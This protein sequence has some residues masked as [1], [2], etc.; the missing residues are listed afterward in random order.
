M[1]VA[2]LAALALVAAA[3]GGAEPVET[4]TAAPNG[5]EIV[6]AGSAET[7]VP[8][9][10][11]TTTPD[12]AAPETTESIPADEADADDTTPAEDT[13][14][15]PDGSATSDDNAKPEDAPLD[16]GATI[17]FR[18]SVLK[19]AVT[20]EDGDTGVPSARFSFVMSMTPADGGA[21]MDMTMAGAFD[22]RV[23]ATHLTMDMSDFFADLG[24]GEEDPFLEFFLMMF[25]EPIEV[26]QIGDIGWVSGDMFAAFAPDAAG[27]WVETT[28]TDGEVELEAIDGLGFS[29]PNELL[30]QFADGRGTITEVGTEVLRWV[31]T[32]HYLVVVDLDALAAGLD[33]AELA[34]LEAEFGATSGTLPID[35][36]LDADGNAHRFSIEI[37]GDLLGTG[38]ED[39]SS[40]SVVFEIWDHGADVGI[41]P[42]PADLVISEDEIGMGFDA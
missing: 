19:Q 36:W 18:D 9:A 12:T 3:C 8:A 35:I 32:T 5:G 13:A 29:D 21:P 27:K 7:T 20:A 25:A 16:P 17:A 6:I 33:A 14:T 10:P 15:K 22:A 23:P 39:I 2:L 42:P 1:V 28:A 31:E 41:A 30:G 4:S 38:D 37:A 26:I 11:D 40:A 34:E 24:E